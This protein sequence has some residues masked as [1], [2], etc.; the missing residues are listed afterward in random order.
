MYNKFH[1]VYTLLFITLVNRHIIAVVAV[2]AVVSG[3]RL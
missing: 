1:G 2:A 3:W